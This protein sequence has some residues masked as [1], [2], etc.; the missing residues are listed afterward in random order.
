MSWAYVG[1][2]ILTGANETQYH[3]GKCRLYTGRQPMRSVATGS[4]V[5][6]QTADSQPTNN[7]Q[8]QHKEF[9]EFL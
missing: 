6:S 2:R 3:E 9:E 4:K 8:A 7:Q 5:S 1:P